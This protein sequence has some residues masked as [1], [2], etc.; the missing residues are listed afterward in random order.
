MSINQNDSAILTKSINYSS[1]LLNASITPQL[2]NNKMFNLQS[3]STS[4]QQTQSQSQP[5]KITKSMSISNSLSPTINQAGTSTSTSINGYSSNSNILHPSLFNNNNHSQSS[6]LAPIQKN[7]TQA[8]ILNRKF[9][10]DY[11]QASKLLS[12]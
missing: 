9:A 6:V 10:S 2:N 1:R 8:L 7:S 3:Q 5:R 12:N 4:Q 11:Q